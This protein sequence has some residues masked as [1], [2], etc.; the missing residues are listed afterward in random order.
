[1][2]AD[3]EERRWE[4]LRTSMERGGAAEVIRYI[5]AI[6][7]PETRRTVYAIAQKGFGNRHGPGRFRRPGRGGHGGNQRDAQQALRRRRDRVET[8]RFRE[9]P[10]ST[11][12]QT[13][14]VLTGR[15]GAA[16]RGS[17]GGIR[18]RACVPPGLRP[19][20]TRLGEASGPACDGLLGECGMHQMSLGISTRPRRLQTASGLARLSNK[21]A[22]AGTRVK[23]GSTSA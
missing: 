4:E 9:P 2:A 12:P 3:L 5:E 19:V 7:D 11:W 18:K 22:R 20:A 13:S 1:M 14:R 23:S 10:L 17:H 16:R 8:H 6:E 21:Q 15:R